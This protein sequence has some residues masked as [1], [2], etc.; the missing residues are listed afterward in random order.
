MKKLFALALTASA[1][2]AAAPASAAP[3]LFQITGD[4]TY[5]FIIDSSPVPSNVSDGKG[6]F[7]VSN[8]PGTF[9]T[10]GVLANA[11][12]FLTGAAAQDGGLELDVPGG[13]FFFTGTVLAAPAD[14]KFFGQLFI[15]TL[16]A[17]VFKL[18][19][20]VLLDQ[21][22][23]KQNLT[24][25]AAPLSAVPEPATWAMMLAGF[26]MVGFGLRSRRNGKVTTKVAFA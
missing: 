6:F 12:F 26:G 10:N 19:Q 14:Q 24:I 17:P 16:S 2:A 13:S 4:H 15:G 8:I 9:G 7:S 25:S 3:L 5:A 18:G 1:L 20:F 23:T 11:N 21:T 22:G